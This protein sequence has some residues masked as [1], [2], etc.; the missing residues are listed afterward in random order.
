METPETSMK[1]EFVALKDAVQPML[2]I[3]VPAFNEASRIVDSIKK[4][5]AFMRRASIS[6]ELIIVDDG[7]SDKTAEIVTRALADRLRLV[8][9][10]KNHGKGYTVRQGVLAA[11]G[12]YVLFTD[13]DLSAPIEEADKLL[14]VALRENVDIVIGS[15][16]ID[17]KYI[18]KHQARFRELG[19]IVFNLMVRTLLGLALHDTQ[20]GFKLFHRQRSR[21]IFEQQTTSGFGFDP[22]LL[23]L[24]KRNGLSIRE[25]PVR[26]SHAEGSKIRF[27][28]DSVRMFSD[29][30]RIRWNALSGRYS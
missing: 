26:W 23:F 28:R 6:T 9:N 24:A 30:L 22:E 21:R 5:D 19:G 25:I 1:R 11:K 29:L 3:V 17:R 20:C 7:S 14:D 16:A 13:A 18:E 15:R 4:I 8:R 2:S 27:F 12:K 10:S